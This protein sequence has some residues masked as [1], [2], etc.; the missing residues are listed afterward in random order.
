[1]ATEET[2]MTRND[3]RLNE[4][5][6]NHLIELRDRFL[7]NASAALQALMMSLMALEVSACEDDND[8]FSLMFSRTDIRAALTSDVEDE[9]FE[10]RADHLYQFDLPP[11]VTLTGLRSFIQ[12]DGF[13]RIC[14]IH[15]GV[16]LADHLLRLG[17]PLE[18]GEVQAALHAVEDASISVSESLVKQTYH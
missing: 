15:L 17:Y 16:S 14:E 13:L 3:H 9:A 8:R 11:G 18:M 7:G 1:M 2:F 4:A 6:Y 10:M 5:L 12:N